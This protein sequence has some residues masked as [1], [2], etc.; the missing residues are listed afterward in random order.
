MD[1]VLWCMLV[2]FCVYLEIMSVSLK[3]VKSI[4]GQ[5]LLFVKIVLAANP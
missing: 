3:V 1:C 5:P 4:F 2:C